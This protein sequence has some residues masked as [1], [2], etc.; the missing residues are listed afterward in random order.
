[1]HNPMQHAD[2]YIL[3]SSYLSSDQSLVKEKTGHKTDNEIFA[4]TWHRKFLNF[5]LLGLMLLFLKVQYREHYML[6]YL[7]LLILVTSL[8]LRNNGD[9]VIIKFK[10]C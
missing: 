9:C 5:V 4:L 7:S 6:L 1:M 2:L 3:H 8:N 10:Q